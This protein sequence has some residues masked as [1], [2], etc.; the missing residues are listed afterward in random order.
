MFFNQGHTVKLSVI[1]SIALLVYQQ[2][3]VSKAFANKSTTFSLRPFGLGD[4]GG[5]RFQQTVP[6]LSIASRTYEPTVV[7]D[8]L[9]RG[10]TS[11]TRLAWLRHWHFS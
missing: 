10:E 6:S 1:N 8:A 3:D 9:P 5:E 11:K 4:E 2:N 7:C